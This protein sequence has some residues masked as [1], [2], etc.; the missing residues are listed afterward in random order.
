MKKSKKHYGRWTDADYQY[1]KDNYK[2]MSN[3][4]MAQALDRTPISIANQRRLLGLDN[5]NYS[6]RPNSRH[7]KPSKKV[8]VNLGFAKFTLSR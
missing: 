1:I 2:Q 3:A 7:G 5:W 6:K 4:E 8:S